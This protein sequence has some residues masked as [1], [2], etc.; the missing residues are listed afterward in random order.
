MKYNIDLIEQLRSLQEAMKKV[1]KL[2]L[3]DRPFKNYAVMILF[4][5]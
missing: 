4:N 3:K 2:Q 5:C 1:L